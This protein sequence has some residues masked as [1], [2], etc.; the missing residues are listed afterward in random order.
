MT[1]NEVIELLK[2][3]RGFHNEALEYELGE[4]I[5]LLNELM[6]RV[7]RAFYDMHGKKER[8]HHVTNQLRKVAANCIRAMEQHGAP[9]RMTY[10]ENYAPWTS[11]DQSW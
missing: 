6:S 4:E 7:N 1:F 2:E 5:A 11:S 9:S 3:E 10:K 8:Y